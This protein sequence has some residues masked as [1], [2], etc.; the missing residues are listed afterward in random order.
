MR[1]STG[2]VVLSGP[3]LQILQHTLPG[4]PWEGLLGPKAEVGDVD[5]EGGL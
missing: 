3:R 2:G 1:A 4:L 5:N